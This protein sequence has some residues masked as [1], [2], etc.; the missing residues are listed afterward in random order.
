[1]ASLWAGSRAEA[2]R[3]ESAGSRLNVS[4]LYFCP[5]TDTSDSGAR[6]RRGCGT[7]WWVLLVLYILWLADTLHAASPWSRSVS[8]AVLGNRIGEMNPLLVCCRS[9]RLG[10]LLADCKFNAT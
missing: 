5:S 1:M 2:G 8:I 7:G 10:Q 4:D 3:L 6:K 9:A